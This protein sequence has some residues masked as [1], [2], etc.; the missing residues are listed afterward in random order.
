[1]GCN[2]AYAPTWYGCLKPA[3]RIKNST[4]RFELRCLFC[5]MLN[6]AAQYTMSRSIVQKARNRKREMSFAWTARTSGNFLT[7]MS[8]ETWCHSVAY[9]P[10][11]RPRALPWHCTASVSMLMAIY[12]NKGS[13]WSTRIS[14]CFIE[15]RALPAT[16]SINTLSPVCWAVRKF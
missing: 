14:A 15:A 16:L 8:C 5:L 6:S 1:M 12:M 2:N 9:T 4:A 13:K 10:L 11:V 3:F 7:E